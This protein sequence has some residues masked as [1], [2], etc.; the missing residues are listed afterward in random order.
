VNKII[1]KANESNFENIKHNDEDGNEYWRARELQEVLNYKEW[2][3]FE[4]VIKTA[5]IACKISQHEVAEHFIET[6]KAVEM[7]IGG[8]AKLGIVDVNK[9]E[10]KKTRKLKDYK[11][12]RYACYLIVMNGDPRKEVIANGQTY[13]AVKTRQQEF[14][15]LYAQLTEDDKRLFLRGDIRQKNMLLAECAKNA[16]IITPVEY[17]VFQDY[18]YKG[19]YDGETAKNI[20]DRKGIDAEKESILDYMG[21]LELAANL[22][23]IAQTEDIMRKNDIDNPTEANA[24]HFRVGKIV[25]EAMQKAGSVMPEQ[26]P[27][28]EK[29]IS[30]IEQQKRKQ[31]KG[32]F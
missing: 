24:T 8:K 20:A 18:G 27:T 22:F 3:N 14:N 11:L 13:F 1:Q 10:S 17:A 7:A 4:K 12:S 2:R 26:L 28:P 19:L 29:G 32:S 5:Q 30:Q 16:G 23:R 31:I 9:T 6:V 15:D 21:S 25:R